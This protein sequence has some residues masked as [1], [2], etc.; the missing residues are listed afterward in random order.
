MVPEVKND[1][2]IYAVSFCKERAWFFKIDLAPILE[3]VAWYVLEARQVGQPGNLTGLIHYDDQKCRKL[4]SVPGYCFGALR[5]MWAQKQCTADG[6][7]SRNT[8]KHG[9]FRGYS[10]EA[11]KQVCNTCPVVLAR[12]E[13]CPVCC[14]NSLARAVKEETNNVLECNNATRNCAVH[15]EYC[16]YMD[17]AKAEETLWSLCHAQFSQQFTDK[18]ERLV[19]QASCSPRIESSSDHLSTVPM[20]PY[21]III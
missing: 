18:A 10:P 14:K 7:G 3:F 19:P 11:A 16:E 12:A 1:T 15:E 8:E 13:C 6:G 2:M 21:L 17:Q 20:E 4:D 9:H 5:G